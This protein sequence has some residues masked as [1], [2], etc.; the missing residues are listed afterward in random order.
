M[1]HPPPCPACL[2]V[3]ERFVA[4]G[5]ARF[6]QRI[7]V[8]VLQ[9]F[10]ALIVAAVGLVFVGVSVTIST[11]LTSFLRVAACSAASR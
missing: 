5:F 6:A 11:H 10:L 1:M 8:P 7:D 2:L 3:A 4:R 9:F